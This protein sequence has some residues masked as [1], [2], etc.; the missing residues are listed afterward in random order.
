[1]TWETAAGVLVV[2]LGGVGVELVRW[3]RQRTREPIEQHGLSATADLTV[4]QADIAAEEAE[5]LRL[6]RM[7]RLWERLEDRDK[8]VDELESRVDDLS[9]DLDVERRARQRS[10]RKNREGLRVTRDYADQLRAMVPPPPPP[11]PEGW[12]EIHSLANLTTPTPASSVVEPWQVQTVQYPTNTKESD[13][14]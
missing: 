6:T 12:S 13:N 11:Y 4:A 1:M 5:G 7:E 14:G 9:A 10:D 2:L 8:K 3:W